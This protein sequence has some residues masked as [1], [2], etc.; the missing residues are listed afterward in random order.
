MHD[1][2]QYGADFGFDDGGHDTL[3]SPIGSD[4]SNSRPSSPN[5]RYRARLAK[6]RPRRATSF[7]FGDVS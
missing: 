5:S 1:D 2:V 3:E 7:A 6:G 4:S